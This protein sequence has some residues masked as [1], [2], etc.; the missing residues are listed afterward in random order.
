MAT[1]LTVH[2]RVSSY[3][4][5]GWTKKLKIH[6]TSN[7]F[8]P[9]RYSSAQVFSHTRRN[10]R[11]KQLVEEMGQVCYK[12]ISSRER[13]KQHPGFQSWSPWLALPGPVTLIKSFSL[14]GPQFPQLSQRIRG[15]HFLWWSGDTLP[16]TAW[17]P[18]SRSLYV[19]RLPPQMKRLNP[20]CI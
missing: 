15:T 4:M 9:S 17:T 16:S 12:R 18:V 8:H 5:E 2:I 19:S 7:L 1:H 14:P 10:S 20:G 6:A 11:R 13:W 3:V